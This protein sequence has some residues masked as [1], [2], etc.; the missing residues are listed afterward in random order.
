VSLMTVGKEGFSL[1]GGDVGSQLVDAG[2][3]G[4]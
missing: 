2:K 3:N 4:F 1:G